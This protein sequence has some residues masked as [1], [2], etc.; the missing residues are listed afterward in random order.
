MKIFKQGKILVEQRQN[1]DPQ[2]TD[3]LDSLLSLQADHK[4]Y[5]APEVLMDSFDAM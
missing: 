5:T 1:S 2:R 4:E 3:M